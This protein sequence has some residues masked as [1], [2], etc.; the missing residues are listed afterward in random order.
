MLEFDSV[1]LTDDL[2]S[3]A[4]KALGLGDVTL[5]EEECVQELNLYY[6]AC[7]RAKKYLYNATMLEV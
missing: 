1:T 3:S 7:S 6:V 2:N 5:S 4:S